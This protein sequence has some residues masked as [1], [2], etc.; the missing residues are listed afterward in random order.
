VKQ[1]KGF[2]SAK[3][4]NEVL[5]EMPGTLVDHLAYHGE[6]FE[7]VFITFAPDGSW[8]LTGFGGKAFA[9]M[10]QVSD[11]LQEAAEMVGQ[12]VETMH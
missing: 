3:A 1:R 9:S 11:I 4:A 10:S 7:S 8:F 2:K 12:D 6:E 5:A